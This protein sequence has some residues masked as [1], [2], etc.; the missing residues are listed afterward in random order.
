MLVNIFGS[1]THINF[2]I[3]IWGII[4]NACYF[5]SST[6]L[7]KIFHIK[8]VYIY[9]SSQKKIIVEFIEWPHSKGYICLILNIFF[10]VLF[11]LFSDS[12]S[13]FS[14]LSRTVKLPAVPQKNDSG[15]TNHWCSR[16]KHNALRAWRWKRFE[17]EDQGKKKICLLK[18]KKKKKKFFCSF[19]KAALNRKIW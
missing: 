2:F 17:F 3:K 7:N 15:S 5:L 6:D 11:F 16:R 19:W 13:W 8:V 10:F 12:C 9:S 18:K 4:Q 14:C 1:F